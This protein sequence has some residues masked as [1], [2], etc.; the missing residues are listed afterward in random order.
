MTGADTDSPKGSL[1][2][3]ASIAFP[4]ALHNMLTMP[5]HT[6]HG[7]LPGPSFRLGTLTVHEINNPVDDRA[8]QRLFCHQRKLLL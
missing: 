3:P 4:A 5:D 7:L 8:R 6:D 2:Q 1:K